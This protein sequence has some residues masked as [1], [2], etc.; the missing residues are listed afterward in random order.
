[1]DETKLTKDLSNLIFIY[2]TKHKI[3]FRKLAELV[4]MDVSF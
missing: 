3:T 4:N 2:R 1:M